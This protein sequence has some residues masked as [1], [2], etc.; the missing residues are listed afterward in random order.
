M[1]PTNLFWISELKLWSVRILV[2]TCCFDLLEHTDHNAYN[3]GQRIK[4][5]ENSHP[6]RNQYCFLL[7]L[8]CHVMPTGSPLLNHNRVRSSLPTQ[9]NM[10]SCL[11]RTEAEAWTFGTSCANVQSHPCFQVHPHLV[12]KSNL[13]PKSQQDGCRLTNKYSMLQ[14]HLRIKLTF[15][16]GYVP[17]QLQYKLS[18]L[19]KFT[20][21]SEI[22]IQ[23]FL[24]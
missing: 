5:Q 20:C 24:L 23:L 6:T 1:Y 12:N 15:Q 13:N 7:L 17:D 16:D 21:T 10:S 9:V 18:Y 22:T 19:Q 14:H 8:R 4:N 2:P 11:H 3:T